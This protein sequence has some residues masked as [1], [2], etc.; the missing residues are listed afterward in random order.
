[1]QIIGQQTVEAQLT[2]A[3]LQIPAEVHGTIL[4]NPHQVMEQ[5]FRQVN[6][7]QRGGQGRG[8]PAQA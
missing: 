6:W 7:S 4:R 5:R 8:I 3:K 1:M 2:P